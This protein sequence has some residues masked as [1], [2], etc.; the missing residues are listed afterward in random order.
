MYSIAVTTKIERLKPAQVC[1]VATQGNTQRRRPGRRGLP[2]LADAVVA[3]RAGGN[4]AEAEGIRGGRQDGRR[5]DHRHRPPPRPSATTRD[6]RN[7]SE[8]SRPKREN[9]RGLSFYALVLTLAKVAGGQHGCILSS[10]AMH[11]ELEG[12]N[13]GE[14]T[15]R[16]ARETRH[17]AG[18]GSGSMRDSSA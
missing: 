2:R 15:A 11:E 8:L 12:Y 18:R 4:Q 9:P 1:T 5:P 14:K 17:T 13:S 3:I 10:R 7:L 16:Q 6:S